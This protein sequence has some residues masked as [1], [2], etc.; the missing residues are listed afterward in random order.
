MTYCE[1]PWTGKVFDLVEQLSEAKA[2]IARVEA[3]LRVGYGGG[4][5]D[6]W[7]DGARAVQARVRAALDGTPGVSE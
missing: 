4:Y 3:E 1:C 7:V 2:A 5:K 6:M